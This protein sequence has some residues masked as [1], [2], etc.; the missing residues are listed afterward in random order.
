MS[1]IV[2]FS[3]QPCQAFLLFKE[4]KGGEEGINWCI[5]IDVGTS[6]KSLI[7]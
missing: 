5:I 4:V 6:G 1:L 7:R 3:Y 2:Y